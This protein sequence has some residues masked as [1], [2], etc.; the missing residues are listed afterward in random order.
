MCAEWLWSYYSVCIFVCPNGIYSDD[1]DDTSD[2]HRSF[3]TEKSLRIG[4]FIILYTQKILHRDIFTQ[5]SLYKQKLLHWEVFTRGRGAFKHSSL[6][7]EKLL[8]GTW[9]SNVCGFCLLASTET[10]GSFMARSTS[11]T[12]KADKSKPLHQSFRL[13]GKQPTTDKNGW[14]RY[15][16]VSHGVVLWHGC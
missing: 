2:L 10:K 4:A 6:Y 16:A 3:C 7:T 9:W 12:E 8:H 11:S 14:Q 13:L 15:G 1:C 5:R